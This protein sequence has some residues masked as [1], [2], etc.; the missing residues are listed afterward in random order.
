MQDGLYIKSVSLPL[1]FSES[2][3][4]CKSYLTKLEFVVLQLGAKQLIGLRQEDSTKVIMRL[5]GVS[6]M[7]TQVSLAKLGEGQHFAPAGY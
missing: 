5:E 1:G 6:D 7:E 4:L 3:T 2:V